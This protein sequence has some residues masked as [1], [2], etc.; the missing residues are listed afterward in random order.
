[1]NWLTGFLSHSTLGNERERLP[2][3]IALP[4]GDTAD[5]RTCTG[6]GTEGARFEFSTNQDP[7]RLKPLRTCFMH[8]LTMNDEG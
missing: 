1:M 4:P 5:D 6:P 8:D 2:I 7:G 3:N